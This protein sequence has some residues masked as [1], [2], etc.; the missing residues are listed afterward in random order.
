[1]IGKLALIGLIVATVV[2]TILST[3]SL[4]GNVTD[5]RRVVIEIQKFKF[6]PKMPVVKP[7]D[8]IVW[9]NKDIVP[10]TASAKDGSWDSC[11]IK[12][13]GKW[14]MVVKKRIGEKLFLSISSE[15]ARAAEH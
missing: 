15:H 12:S 5:G 6:A 14:E 2:V 10:H 13:K 8:V 1:M 4:A 3:P 9:V 11:K 7:G